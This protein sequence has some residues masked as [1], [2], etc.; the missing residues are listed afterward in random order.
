[1]ATFV[2]NEPTCLTV[3]QEA[4]LPEVFYTV[5]ESGLDPI[6]EVCG[7]LS[8]LV[9]SI[10]PNLGCS[11]RPERYGCPLSQPSRTRSTFGAS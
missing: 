7:V 3:I 9:I 1:M 8:E 11:I 2:H 5:V 6:I 4:G 10:D